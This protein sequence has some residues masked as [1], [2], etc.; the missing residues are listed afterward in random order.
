MSG[1]KTQGGWG[2]LLR[3]SNGPRALVV[4]GG[5]AM[6][7]INVF[8]VITILP[9]VVRDIGGISYFAW[10]TTLYVIASVL[11]G[12]FC[13]RI[14]PRIGARAH[15]RG[16]LALFAVGS[17]ICALAP[18]MPV[19]LAGRLVQ[20]LGAG[21]VSALSYTM[22]RALFPERLWPTAISVISASWGIATCFG[23][24]LGGLFAE[25][26][27]WRWAFWSVA[28]VVPLLWLLVERSL[29][30]DLAR[31][32]LPARP[33]AY[34]NL[35]LLCLSVLAVSLGSADPA[36]WRNLLGFAV[37]VGG[38]AWFVRLERGRGRRLMPHGATNPVT[39]LGATFAAMMAVVVA[40]NTEIFVPYFLQTLHAMAPINA[41]YLSALMSM[42]WTIG[43]VAVAGARPE[44]TPNWMRAGP[45]VI[46][47]ALAGMFLL[48]PRA[49]VLP[50]QTALLGLC[51]LAQGCGIGMCW[52][53]VCA[54]VFRFAADSE[55]DLA[56][57]SMTMVIM[58]SNALG[59]ALAGM[60]TNLAGF[61]G[62]GMP[63]AAMAASWLFGTYVAA[64]LLAFLAIR[65][66]LV[67]RLRA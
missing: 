53:H 27:N 65:R 21:S 52:P 4:G 29:P 19:L 17:A 34:L 7:A 56:A 48:L 66:I 61:S 15:Y 22:V 6:H 9:S 60:V 30:R 20:G 59:S 41:G 24:A 26:S 35:A 50:G 63:G 23:P 43:A 54:G 51:L 18:S 5:M 10:N 28:A 32:P 36:P 42:G 39:G 3:G 47:L 2:D 49:G 57:A 8:I 67:L 33:M 45:I 13:A 55:K 31:P 58:V 40:V 37:A 11:A 62:G 44:L 1:G 16:A 25:G 14:L 12:G 46:G 38:L 64:P